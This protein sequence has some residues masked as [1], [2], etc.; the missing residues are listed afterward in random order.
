MNHMSRWRSVM[1]DMCHW[2]WTVVM[3]N[4]CAVSRLGVV[5]NNF[6]LWSYCMRNSIANQSARKC[7]TKAWTMMVVMVNMFVA[8]TTTM[9][10]STCHFDNVEPREVLR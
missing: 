3:Y 5:D 7:S 1:M 4:R 10:T 8:M 9:R 2:R 6:M